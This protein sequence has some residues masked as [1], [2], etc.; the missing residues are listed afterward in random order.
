[1]GVTYYVENVS[2]ISNGKILGGLQE[3]NALSEGPT[4]LRRRAQ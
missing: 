2:F 3:L 4:C 1:M